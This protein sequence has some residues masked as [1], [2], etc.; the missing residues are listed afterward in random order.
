LKRASSRFVA[1]SKVIQ[2]RG[3]LTFI[4]PVT[5][6]PKTHP[7]V[8]IRKNASAQL[9]AWAIHFGLTPSSEN[10]LAKGGDDGAEGDNPFA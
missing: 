2:K 3:S 10:G 7:A 8:V 4:D 9:R 6:N 5:G 1:A